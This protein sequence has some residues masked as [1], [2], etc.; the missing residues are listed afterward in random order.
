MLLRTTV[1]AHNAPNAAVLAPLPHSLR[2]SSVT[3][4]PDFA[5]RHAPA[6]PNTPPPMMQISD[7]VF[8]VDS[9]RDERVV[10]CYGINLLTVLKVFAVE[11]CAAR[12]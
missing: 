2:S 7:E 8:M 1:D 11:C 6:K 12:F 10:Y 5:N 3:C 4:L 9:V